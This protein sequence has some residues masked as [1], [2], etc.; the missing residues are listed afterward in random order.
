MLIAPVACDLP[1][2][3]FVSKETNETQTEIL[4]YTFSQPELLERALTH[5]SFVGGRADEE[6]YERLEFLGDSILGALMAEHLFRTY[7]ELREGELTRIKSS[8]VSGTSLSQVAD[9]LGLASFIRFGESEKG[10]SRGKTSALENVYEALCG[11]I[12]LDGGFEAAKNF[13][14]ATLVPLVSLDAA[15]KPDSP[16]S[17]L[18]EYSQKHKMGMPR[19]A[20]VQEDGPPHARTF[21]AEVKLGKKVVGTGSGASKKE[22]EAAAASAALES[23]EKNQRAS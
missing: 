11:A 10:V 2:G 15:Y 4:G 9:A 22:A 20:I 19:Y 14:D 17:A 8:L 16:K 5:P 7:P 12:Y 21:T 23:F 1:Q 6:S 18:Q 13:V 3:V